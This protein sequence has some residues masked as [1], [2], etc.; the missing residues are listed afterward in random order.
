VGLSHASSGPCRARCSPLL[1]L[2]PQRWDVREWRLRRFNA[3][4][5]RVVDKCDCNRCSLLEAMFMLMGL[6]PAFA[7]ASTFGG[8]G[9]ELGCGIV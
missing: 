3:L 8:A 6:T 2:Y 7:V 5:S 9:A 4:V 1:G